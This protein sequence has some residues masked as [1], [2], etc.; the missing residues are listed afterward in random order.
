MRITKN[1]RST[2]HYIGII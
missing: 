2:Y 1:R